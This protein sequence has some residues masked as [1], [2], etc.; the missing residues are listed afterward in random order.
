MEHDTIA[1]ICRVAIGLALIAKIIM[2]FIQDRRDKKII[3]VTS[4]G[5]GH[6]D[7]DGNITDFTL[8]GYD[9]VK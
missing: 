8:D 6:V 2:G 4:R 9:I 7:K 3:H 1:F 5:R